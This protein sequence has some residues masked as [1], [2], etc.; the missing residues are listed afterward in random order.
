MW[1]LKLSS[2]GDDPWVTSMNNHIGRQYWEF[3]PNL[4]TPEER[5]HVEKLR[6]DF[7]MNRLRMGSVGLATTVAPCFFFLAW[8][9]MGANFE[10]LFSLFKQSWLLTLSM[11]MVPC[12][13]KHTTLLETPREV[14]FAEYR[15]ISKGGWPFSTPDSGWPVS[16]C[17]AC[18][19]LGGKKEGEGGIE[20]GLGGEVETPRVPSFGQVR[21]HFLPLEL[22]CESCTKSSK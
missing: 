10:M 9:T 19:I 12:L 22:W 1:K 17:T 8:D 20:R 3:D 4:G 5:A 7:T 11:N 18:W 15:H 6:N 13:K 16:D 14:S 2:Q 21:T